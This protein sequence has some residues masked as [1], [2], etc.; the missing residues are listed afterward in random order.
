MKELEYCGIP[1]QNLERLIEQ[2]YSD[3]KFVE[4]AKE[5]VRMATEKK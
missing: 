4:I 2:T 5:M 1:V 3:K